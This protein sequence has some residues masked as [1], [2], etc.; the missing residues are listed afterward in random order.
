MVYDNT[1]AIGV[2]LPQAMGLLTDAH[3]DDSSLANFP[4]R[5]DA[6][7]V[8]HSRGVSDLLR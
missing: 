1:H 2:D 8:I 7:S 5:F 4:R 6:V 3:R